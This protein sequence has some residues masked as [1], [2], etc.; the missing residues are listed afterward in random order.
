MPQISVVTLCLFQ[1][2]GYTI[3]TV[4]LL[5]PDL[6]VWSRVEHTSLFRR[7]NETREVERVTSSYEALEGLIFCP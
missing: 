4:S 6:G 3:P 5:S 2:M 1:E 7:R